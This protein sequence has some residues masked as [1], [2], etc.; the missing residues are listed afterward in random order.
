MKTIPDWTIK[1]VPW[2]HSE[3]VFHQYVEFNSARL[4]DSFSAYAAFL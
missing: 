1:V 2:Y 4:P 3:A